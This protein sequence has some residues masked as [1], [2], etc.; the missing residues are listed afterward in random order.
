MEIPVRRGGASGSPVGYVD[1]DLIF[2][3]YPE[4]KKAREEY[5]K[6]VARYKG[7]LA[8]KER[9]LEDLKGEIEALKAP[10]VSSTNTLLSSGTV[11]GEPPAVS[12]TPVSLA[13]PTPVASVSE[14]EGLAKRQD[15]LVKRQEEIEK[16]RAEATLALRNFEAR[17]S[18]QILG[19]LYKAL[20]QLADERGLSLVVDKSAILYGTNTVDLTEALS[21]RVRGLP[22]EEK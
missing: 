6:E 17:Q 1:M 12:T 5:R 13:P 2:R 19:R 21:R 8:E 7:E 4:T 22:D 18:K 14:A 20:V 10:P 9:A 15:Q 16:A 3:E 11:T